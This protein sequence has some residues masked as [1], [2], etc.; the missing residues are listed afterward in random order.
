[1]QTGIL[2]YE[3]NHQLRESLGT[4]IT[5]SKDLLL[6]GSFG[7]VQEVT[8]QVKDFQPEVILMDIDMPGLNG[9]EAV[10]L[11]RRFNSQVHIIM[12]TVFDDN[13]NVYSAICAGASGYLLK[14]NISNKLLS[15]ITEVMQGEVPMSPGLAR[16]VIRNIQEQ[17]PPGEKDYGL[18]PREKEILRSLSQG[19]SYKMM[20]ASFHISID[21][22]RSH[23]KRIYEKLQVH[24]QT[25]AIAKLNNEKL[26]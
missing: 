7:N 16:M 24:S 6:L 17:A 18:S 21:T 20:A 23:I 8:Q 15:A 12:L 1:M 9:I 2:I 26:L 14:K 22:V 13:N 10:K 11:I 3:D 4:M 25:E 19:N 5:L